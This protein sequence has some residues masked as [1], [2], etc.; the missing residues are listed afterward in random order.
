VEPVPAAST[1]QVSHK[2]RGKDLSTLCAIAQA[3]CNH[4]RSAEVITFVTDRLPD[5][6]PDAHID[7]WLVLAR[8]VAMNRLLHSDG[9]VQGV[10]RAS[11]CHHQAIAK[12]L[13]LN[14]VRR[15]DRVSKQSEMCTPQFLGRLVAE[16]IEQRR[17][18]N[19]ISEQ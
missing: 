7:A 2:L 18:P 13:D 10:Q 11:K 12:I 14:A 16:L 4:Y 17:R 5:V 15:C 6:E 3:L 1:D 19:Q 9:A 8:V